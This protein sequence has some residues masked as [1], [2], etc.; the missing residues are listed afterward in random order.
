MTAALVPVDEDAAADAVAALEKLRAAETR[1]SEAV[2]C[3]DTHD[4][5]VEALALIRQALGPAIA[6]P[7][8][9]GQAA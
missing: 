9:V 5:C 1:L 6:A 2:Q 4:A 8:Q 7:A 3:G